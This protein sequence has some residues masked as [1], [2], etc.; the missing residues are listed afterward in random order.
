MKSTND[1]ISESQAGQHDA[2]YRDGAL[3]LMTPQDDAVQQFIRFLKK[4]GWIVLVG[5]AIGLTVAIILNVVMQKRYTANATIEVSEDRT[6]EFRL[7]SMASEEAG[8]DSGTKLDTEI[9]VLK[10]RTLA[11]EV[12]RTLHL[13]SN[14]DFAELV[15]GKPLDLSRADVREGLIETF[16]ANLTVERVNHTD[17]LQIS[18]TSKRPELASLMANTLI[19]SYIEHTFRDSYNS[20]AKI[21][22]WLDTQLSG[23]KQNLQK[24][25]DQMVALQKD[26]GF[27]GGDQ[28]DNVRLVT[29]EE[30]N[31]QLADAEVDTL[32][33]E[34]QYRAYKTADPS[35]IQALAQ[36]QGASGGSTAVSDL[37]ELKSEYASL[38]QSY[39]A[40]Y[41]RVKQL[42]AQIAALQSS[43]DQETSA[44]LVKA[45]KELEAAHNNE[46]MLR[47]KLESEEQ[48][49]YQL[50]AKAVDYEVVRS[51]YES[52][53]ELYDGLQQRL[54]EASITAGLQSSSVHPVDS[55]DLPIYPS[56]PRK[57][58]NL[59][60][61]L[62]AGLILGFAFAFLRESLD[63]NLKSMAE[64]E[65]GLQLP[66]LAALPAVPAEDLQPSLFAKHAVSRGTS[67]WS[68]VA[69]ALRGMRT[70]ILLSSAGSP[71]KV[72]MLTSS[73]PAEGKTAVSCLTS[74][75]L[76]LNG[77]RVLLIDADL[78][79]PSVHV[80]F[81]ISKQYGLS[82]VLS[83]KMSFEDAVIPWPELPNVHL[84]PS[85]PVPP[86]PSELLGSKQME[87]LIRS[88]RDQYDFILIDT[89][90]VLT[91][92]DAAIMSRI[93]DASILI[94]RYGEVQR[95]VA[96]RSV[97]M[98][99]RFGARVL[100]IAVN[101]VD[102]EAPEYA[103][104]YGRKYYEYYGERDPE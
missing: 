86:L 31:K 67:A 22:Q 90:P 41:P 38:L 26:V 46:N 15:N 93:A 100:G 35:V 45:Q 101:A 75:T 73:R 54:Q 76:A 89:P 83:G 37:V 9:E 48:S 66:V 62:G 47:A 98:L 97:D 25:Q 20:T 50:G 30:L 29:L 70:S 65:N 13:E 60:G 71:P 84:L 3:A 94:V 40:A 58:L 12:I 18:V 27:V 96:L 99:D 34:A 82:S 43:L 16:I 72:I 69:E 1:Q 59:A 88:V 17:L 44:Q 102:F 11:L 56:K 74:I 14:P 81:K 95:Q 28:G 19:D 8:M 23:L 55:A 57:G 79:R 78:R 21:S 104:Y 64:I 6:G 2:S 4:R 49:V 51:Q 103:E 63:I 80:R 52:N 10:S 32:V 61:G 87:D 92:T 39:G 5:G 68:R 77:S 36:S 85:G 33:K 91:V 53:R 7:E 42:K 24:S